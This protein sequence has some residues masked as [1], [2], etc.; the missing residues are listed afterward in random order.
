RMDRSEFI[1]F[2][3]EILSKGSD[4][5][6]EKYDLDIQVFGNVALTTG[7]ERWSMVFEG[8]RVGGTARFTM[9]FVKMGDEWKIIHEHFTN[10]S[11]KD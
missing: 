6:N 4:I 3:S 1:S 7:C 11:E 8:K 10:I 5:T 9:V 2:L